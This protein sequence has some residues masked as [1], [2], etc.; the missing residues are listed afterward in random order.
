MQAITMKRFLLRSIR[1][2]ARLVAHA[3]DISVLRCNY[4][5]VLQRIRQYGGKR[6]IKVIFLVNEVSKWKAQSLYSLMEKS[7][8][9]DPYIGLT[10]ADM[11]WHLSTSDQEEKYLANRK[12]FSIKGMKIVDA[13]DIDKRLPISL[14]KYTP[15]IVWYQQPWGIAEE[16]R[17]NYVSYYALTAYIPYY[18][19]NYG[20]IGIDCNHDFHKELWRYF[21]LNKEWENFYGRHF[22]LFSH[23]GKLLGLGHT[24]LDPLRSQ[25]GVKEN[26]RCVI[27][28][29]HWSIDCP[30]NE[31]FEN[32]S[33]FLWTGIPLL[34]FAKEH[35]EIQW[36]FKPHP[37]LKR[38]LL[39][40]GVW[41]KEKIESYYQ[42]WDSIGIKCETGDYQ[43][44]MLESKVMITDCGSFLTEYFS[45]GKPLVHLISPSVK[46]KPLPP[47]RKMFDSFYKVHSMEEL[48]KTLDLL[49]N[50]QKDPK[51]EERLSLIR[52]LDIGSSNAAENILHYMDK[53][54]KID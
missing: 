49:I 54:L 30:G 1:Y 29:P 9:Y 4:A 34:E 14:R 12:Y 27:Y 46:L 21:I 37:T 45:T 26:E 41:S 25:S 47:S 18:V 48:V 38:T 3:F 23:A 31:N 7:K 5:I 32:Y 39:K 53:V 22:A 42:A 24:G 8:T 16:Q 13:Y 11:D 36:I 17:P 20:H 44:L 40:T 19:P 35:K 50:Q 6:K 52:E 15:D 33:T 28:A 43:Q 10:L 51:R 2:I